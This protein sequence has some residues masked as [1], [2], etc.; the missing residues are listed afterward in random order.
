MKSFSLLSLL[1]LALTLSA[2]ADDIV[3]LKRTDAYAISTYK[4]GYNTTAMDPTYQGTPPL[5][6][7]EYGNLERG[8]PTVAAS[9]NYTYYYILNMTDGQVVIIGYFGTGASKRYIVFT[10]HTYTLNDI[11][12]DRIPTR[13]LNT[14]QWVFGSHHDDSTTS[15]ANIKDEAYSGTGSPLVIA[16]N[17]AGYPPRADAKTIPDVPRSL[18]GKR[19]EVY[20]SADSNVASWDL[21]LTPYANEVRYNHLSN[22]T[23]TYSLDT[24]ATPIVNNGPKLKAYDQN[25]TPAGQAAPVAPGIFWDG[26]GALANL[27]NSTTAY[28]VRHLLNNLLVT[29]YR[30]YT[31]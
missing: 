4:F 17:L 27:E 26:S 19:Y 21:S 24:V 28:A 16:K 25:A 20:A 31:P 3:I 29:G 12:V 15:V 2:G 13:T 5:L 6:A 1:L 7:P 23:V 10:E 9:V 22:V 18:T 11:V 30:V 8:S 14:T